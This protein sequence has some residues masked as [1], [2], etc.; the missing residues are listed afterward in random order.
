MDPEPKGGPAGG[1]D[2]DTSARQSEPDAGADLGMFHMTTYLCGAHRRVVLAQ[3]R[4]RLAGGLPCRLVS[5]QL[6]E[7]GV[8][9]D[10]AAVFRALCP[11]DCIIQAAGRANRE[12][13]RPEGG[14]LIVFVP[15]EGS[16]PP[17]PYRVGSD[18]TGSLLMEAL[19]TGV[20]LDEHDPAL[21]RRYFETF[22]RHVSLDTY[23]IQRARAALD[24]PTVDAQF[25]LI[26]DES[27]P[28]V[29]HYG[30]PKEREAVARA[31]HHLRA[32]HGSPL[33]HLRK[34]QPYLVNL[35]QKEFA[36]AQ[37]QGLVSV[38]LPDALWE[39]HGAYSDQYGVM[40]GD[41]LPA[42]G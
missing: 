4:K 32:H 3:V 24:Y 14:R 31:L 23:G 21:C 40:V 22:Y 10:F 2:P 38:V 5:T 25:Q 27:V 17:G 12:G 15:A 9:V 13:K 34:L 41:G 6:I 35:R 18:L 11:L 16:L 7:C 20:P 28:V 30:S 29:V 36:A 1:V 19:T 8:D 33:D 37:A 26:V 39:W 42:L